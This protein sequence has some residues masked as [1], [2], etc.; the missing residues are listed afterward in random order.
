MH[1][2]IPLEPSRCSSCV[3]FQK[4]SYFCGINA[5]FRL[6]GRKCIT[7][8][9]RQFHSGEENNLCAIRFNCYEALK[10]ISPFM[11]FTLK[12][13]AHFLQRGVSFRTITV[14]THMFLNFIK[15]TTTKKE[16]HNN[17][18][19][20]GSLPLAIL[21]YMRQLKRTERRFLSRTEGWNVV[22]VGGGGKQTNLAS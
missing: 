3:S 15:T 8:R 13:F 16:K 9:L 6:G 2:I 22:V 18:E 12:F 21:Q 5:W 1:Q 4:Q 7:T 17:I 11:C 19:L 14:M 10:H 20:E